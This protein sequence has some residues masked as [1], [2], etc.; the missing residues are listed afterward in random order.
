MR[1][2]AV[3]QRP[4]AWVSDGFTEYARRLP[5][6]MALHLTEISPA[7]RK[8]V[9]VQRARG[10]EGERLLQQVGPGDCVV[11]LDVTGVQWSTPQLAQH[12]DDWRMQGQ[13]VAF[14]VGGADGLASECLE[15]ADRVWSLSALTFPHA[16]VRVILAEQ[17]YRAWTLLSGHPYH[18][19]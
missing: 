14:L 4:P 16:L 5:R 2:V 17:L 3:G 9:P 1:L 8:N 15:R 7:P 19:A 10:M 13:D 18:R 6:D 11:A 12:M